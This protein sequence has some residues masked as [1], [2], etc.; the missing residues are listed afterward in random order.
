M[1]NHMAKMLQ[2]RNVPDRIHRV[3]KVRAARAGVS[4]S[5]YVLAELREITARPTL[6]ELFERI[7]HRGSVVLSEST[8]EAVRA[9]RDAR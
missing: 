4:L 1:L 2:I 5:D 7:S 6:E 3:L 9:E 8:E